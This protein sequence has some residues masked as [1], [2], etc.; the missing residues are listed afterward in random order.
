MNKTYRVKFNHHTNTYVAVAE[1]STARG[2][3]GGSGRLVAAALLA[4]GLSLNSGL[5]MADVW[6]DAGTSA[7]GVPEGVAIGALNCTNGANSQ[8]VYGDNGNTY[9]Q[10][11]PAGATFSSTWLAGNGGIAIGSSCDNVTIALENGTAIGNGA[12]AANSAVA[13]GTLALAQQPGTI[14]VGDHAQALGP[15]SIAIGSNSE[16]KGDSAVA[17]GRRASTDG[18]ETVAVGNYAIARGFGSTAL[19]GESSATGASSTALG[20]VAGADADRSVAVGYGSLVVSQ[21]MLPTS[22]GYKWL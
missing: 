9:S 3:S 16:A 11:Y 7:A 4:A 12:A 14:A 15:T 2:K 13:L 10:G 22:N 20:F 17:M 21:A 5:A 6:A 18:D 19:G 1:I 8:I